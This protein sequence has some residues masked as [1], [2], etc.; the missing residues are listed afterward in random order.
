MRRFL[1]PLFALV[2]GM[3]QSLYANSPG[4]TIV[5]SEQVLSELMAIP[6]KQIPH[7][8][9]DEAQGIAIIPNVIKVALKQQPHVNIFGDDYD[10]PDGTCI[11]DYIHVNDLATAHRLALEKLIKEEKSNFYNLGTGK[12]FS[13]KEVIEK[14][15]KITGKL[16][17]KQIS[18]RRE[19]DPPV[20]IADNKKVK[21][22]LGWNPEYTEI[23]DIIVTAWNWELNRKY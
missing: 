8:L 15:E 23:E 14:S 3:T 1:I 19:G 10:T 5:E 6:G 13:V 9:L 18:E 2:L 11:R 21:Q 12:G 22:E 17:N 4:E 16:I 20:L 7:R